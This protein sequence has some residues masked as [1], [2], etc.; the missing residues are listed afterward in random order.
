MT[1]DVQE[2]G[3]AAALR[4]RVKELPAAAGAE[5]WAPACI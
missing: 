3:A 1:G 2:G 4:N 5:G